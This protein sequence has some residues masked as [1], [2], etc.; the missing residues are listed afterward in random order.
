MELKEDTEVR[1]LRAITAQQRLNFVKGLEV[2]DVIGVYCG[3]TGDV[4]HTF[5]WL[6][7]V[8]AKSRADAAIG[9]SPVLFKAAARNEG[10]DVE[11][12]EYILNIQWL[13]R[14]GRAKWWGLA[15]EQVIALTSVLPVRVVWKKQQQYK[16]VPTGRSTS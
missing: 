6:A 13:K 16:S 15:G 1:V 2:G 12:F 9:D 10:W 11:A 4:D 7:K 8:Q 5:F 3:G 14:M